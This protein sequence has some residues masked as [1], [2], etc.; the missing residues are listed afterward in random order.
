MLCSFY[1][2]HELFTYHRVFY[3]RLSPSY[4][5]FL[6]VCLFSDNKHGVRLFHHS[7]AH[8]GVIKFTRGAVNHRLAHSLYLLISVGSESKIVRQLYF[9]F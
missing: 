3:I 9:L 4:L 2:Q 8:A 6:F 1:G 7:Q 5:T